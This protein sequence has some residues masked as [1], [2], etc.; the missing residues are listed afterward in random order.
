MNRNSVGAAIAM[1]PMLL[2]S[3][4]LWAQTPSANP[5]KEIEERIE[6]ADKE[7]KE[8]A[9]KVDQLQEKIQELSRRVAAYEAP[10]SAPPVAPKDRAPREQ[11]YR[12][13]MER[14]INK[15]NS[16]TLVFEDQGVL[17]VDFPAVSRACHPHDNNLHNAELHMSG[18]TSAKSGDF[19]VAY[20]Y[21]KR[22][23]S[24]RLKALWLQRKP[25]ARGETIAEVSE[26]RSPV[27]RALRRGDPDDTIVTCV[28]YPDSYDL[29]LKVRAAAWAEGYELGW[30]PF[31]PGKKLILSEGSGG[32]SKVD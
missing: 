21:E 5:S 28:V 25:N 10:A 27:R 9:S 30:M 23:R 29:F 22:G 7:L 24:I 12:P 11:R 8:V 6:T 19:D 4:M 3:G 31:P 14:L 18:T 16:I 26:L 13:P 2:C 1:F 17:L 15:E 32:P 20:E